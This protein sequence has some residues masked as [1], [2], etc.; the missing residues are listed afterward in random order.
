M[1]DNIIF[2]VG[3]RAGHGKDTFCDFMETELDKH[4]ISWCRNSF[5]KMLKRIVADKY[6]LDDMQMGSQEYKFQTPVQLGGKTIRD[7]LIHEGNTSREIWLHV[8]AWAAFE[9][10]LIADKKVS[11]IS[12]FRFPN[13]FSGF[14]ELYDLYYK[15]CMEA[16]RTP[17]RKPIL[18][19]I[20]VVRDDG[21]HNNDGADGELTD[22]FD[23][24]DYNIINKNVPDWKEQMKQN[25]NNILE[26]ENVI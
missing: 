6:G 20:Q 3:H 24:W 25:I 1:D 15:N 21:T 18:R 26:N 16:N 12:D 4:N 7:V 22:D 2:L 10:L 5:A 14:D 8:W 9:E 19:K 13:E 17:S 11:F 23:Y